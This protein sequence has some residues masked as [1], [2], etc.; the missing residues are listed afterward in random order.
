MY[1]DHGGR[2]G[3]HVRHLTSGLN[4]SREYAAMLATLDREIGSDGA[5]IDL[6]QQLKDVNSELRRIED[7]IRM[8]ERQQR[9]DAEFIA[10]ARAVY[11][12]NDRRALLKR[13]INTLTGGAIVEEKSYEPY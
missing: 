4:V 8:C 7:D 10:L 9:F 5:L 3:D 11:H 6:R 13:Q 12:T 1:R 2:R